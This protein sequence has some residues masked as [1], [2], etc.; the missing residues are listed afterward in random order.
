MG[1]VYP[2][3]VAITV[4]KKLEVPHLYEEYANEKKSQLFCPKQTLGRK[5]ISQN[6]EKPEGF[7]SR[8][9]D[10]FRGKI[11]LLALGKNISAINQIG[12]DIVCCPDGLH[13]VVYKLKRVEE[14]SG[15]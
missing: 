8:S 14:E 4:L 7:C 6:A 12:T 10:A 11:R 13:P 15:E 3:K 1:K 9:W 2:Y 5:F